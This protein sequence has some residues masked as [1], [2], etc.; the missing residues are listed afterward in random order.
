MVRESA[1]ARGLKPATAIRLVCMEH[2][3]YL[4]AQEELQR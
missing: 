3:Y 4:K 1:D 2:L